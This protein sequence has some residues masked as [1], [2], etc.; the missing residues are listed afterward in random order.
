MLRLLV[1]AALLA[2]AA[3]GQTLR[4]ENVRVDLA[5]RDTA[6][7]T[8]P[9]AFDVV[10]E[11]WRDGGRWD[12]A[13]LA[14]SFE[15]SPGV[16]GAIQFA[17]DGLSATADAEVVLTPV[18]AP[19]AAPRGLLL[20]RAADGRGELRTTV[21]ATW[22]HGA[23]FF[24]L[25]ADGVPV[26]LR[27]VEM[28]RVPGGPFE[29][30]EGAVAERQPNSF[31]SADGPFRI[32]S[33]AELAVGGGGLTYAV[34]EGE[35]YAGGDRQGPIPAAFP[36]GTR[37]FYVMTYPVTQG[38][39]AA[40]LSAL[41]A[42]ARAARDVSLSPGYSDNGGT[43]ACAADGCTAALPDRAANY[44]AWADGIGWASWAGLRPMTELEY[45]KA[46]AGTPADSARYADGDLPDR[47]GSSERRSAWGAVDLR[48]GLWERVVTVGTPE[49]RAFAGSPGRGFVDD[50]GVP[51]VFSNADWPGPQAAGS[52]Y[53]G[54][55]EGLLGM[56]EVADRT[57]GAYTATYGD[58]SQGFR[59]VLDAPDAE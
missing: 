54:G 45:E 21:R 7:G 29:V 35:A 40:F 43:I 48:G 39:Y 6:A 46:A 38:Q 4:V 15:R 37:P 26:R 2:P 41:P 25:P 10:W 18:S 42:R 44:L 49:G 1:L 31:G 22:D 52:G 51:Y 24:D 9:V 23:S 58:A 3:V 47:V 32:D 34:P 8:V 19:N 27:G 16:W 53:R 55:T 12:A 28:V 59:A 14:G 30:G 11:A 57:Y 13:W 20:H 33:E 50:F 56:G 5:A 17:I 36:K